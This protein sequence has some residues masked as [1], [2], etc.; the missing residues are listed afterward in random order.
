M[1]LVLIGAEPNEQ[2]LMDRDDENLLI[3]DL[4]VLGIV[5]PTPDFATC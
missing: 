5:E 2:V 1:K 4:Q 3:S